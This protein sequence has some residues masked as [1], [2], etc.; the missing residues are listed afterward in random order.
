MNWKRTKISFVFWFFYLVI[1]GVSAYVTL[2]AFCGQRGIKGNIIYAVVAGVLLVGGLFSVGI[3]WLRNHLLPEIK[4]E[5]N[6]WLLFELLVF[7]GALTG[8]ILLRIQGLPGANPG[9]LYEL[10][11][12]RYQTP[13]P[14]LAQGAENLYLHVLH[15]I[16]FL[17]GNT[18]YFCIRFHLVFTILIGVVWYF[19]VRKMAGSIAGIAVACFYFLDPYMIAKSLTIS[20]EPVS[21]FAFG[22][23]LVF[24]GNCLK[25]H[26]GLWVGYVLTGIWIGI[27]GYLDMV[28]LSLLLFAFSLYHVEKQESQSKI[29]G[30][31]IPL[32]F[33]LLGCLAGFFGCVLEKNLRTGKGFSEVLTEWINVYSVKDFLGPENMKAFF[34]DYP[35]SIASL[36]VI[37]FCLFGIFAFF[38]KGAFERISPWIAGL[39]AYFGMIAF[40]MARWETFVILCMYAL[41]GIGIYGVLVPKVIEEAEEEKQNNKAP[42]REMIDP[43]KWIQ[44]IKKSKEDRKAA[45]LYAVDHPEM[46]EGKNPISKFFY[47]R[48]KKKI[49]NQRDIDKVMYALNSLSGDRV[50]I[51]D[52]TRDSHPEETAKEKNGGL[53]HLKK[54]GEEQSNPQNENEMEKK[55]VRDNTSWNKEEQNGSD[56]KGEI[57]QK[58][59]VQKELI[60]KETIQKEMIQKEMIQEESNHGESV[61]SKDVQTERIP[62]ESLQVERKLDEQTQMEVV[63]NGA[64]STAVREA[65]KPQNNVLINMEENVG[66]HENAD[67]NPLEASVKE[68]DAKEQQ[69]IE[70]HVKEPSEAFLKETPHEIATEEKTETEKLVK[71]KSAEEKLSEKKI[72]EEKLSEEKLPEETLSKE[73]LSKDKPAEEN[74][75]LE[76]LTKEKLTDKES[77]EKTEK[78]QKSKKSWKMGRKKNMADNEPKEETQEIANKALEEQAEDLGKTKLLDN[79]LPLPKKTVYDPMDYDYEV[80]DDD[81]YDIKDDD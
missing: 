58:E 8:G 54:H 57:V 24:V 79:P 53:F 64:V 27:S 34:G 12:M 42:K 77:V 28:C 72:S 71:D 32:I 39:M 7:L 67:K 56:R 6:L 65:D 63:S 69:E 45:L 44:S 31:F 19:G 51:E 74:L 49:E 46:M 40:G 22:L 14:E 66:Q 17:L 11:I 9:N 29:H 41:A 47:A 48:A 5:E 43:G 60:Q 4:K 75:T 16:C 2:D 30:R 73:K 23:G 38:M 21:L 68:K 35:G 20:A 37:A 59:T 26:E 61:K 52:F 36:I 13:A 33:Q 55:S 76:K 70:Q 62:G 50:V 1:V 10:A 18:P 80:S 25:K 3:F 15:G 81:D 78:D